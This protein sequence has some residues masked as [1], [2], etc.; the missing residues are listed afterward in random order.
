MI[1]GLS[2][3]HIELVRHHTFWIGNTRNGRN[4]P[5]FLVQ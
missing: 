1:Q 2:K 4:W 3:D 5:A